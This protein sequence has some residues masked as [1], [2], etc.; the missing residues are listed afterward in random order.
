MPQNDVNSNTSLEKYDARD[1]V[2]A[3]A[4]WQQ[5]RFKAIRIKRGRLQESGRCSYPKDG[6]WLCELA[7][8]Q[9]EHRIDCNVDRSYEPMKS[10]GEL[11]GEFMQDLVAKR[12]G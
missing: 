10:I 6:K 1:W 4:E 9:C 5:E 8:S 12:E 2:R 11:I 3:T 7:C